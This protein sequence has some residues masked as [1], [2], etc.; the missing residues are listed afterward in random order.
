MDSEI[1]QL[2]KSLCDELSKYTFYDGIAEQKFIIMICLNQLID[3]HFTPD[4]LNEIYQKIETALFKM[5]AL[6]S[7]NRYISED[8]VVLLSNIIFRIIDNNAN[9]KNLMENEISTMFSDMSIN[10][11]INEMMSSMEI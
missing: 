8:I 1:L 5:V 6:V 7:A 4:A 2:I 11:N 9:Q 3:F 10:P